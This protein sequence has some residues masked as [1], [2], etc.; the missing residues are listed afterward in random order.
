MQRNWFD[1][2]PENHRDGIRRL[3]P[4]L[5]HLSIDDWHQAVCD[6]FLANTLSPFPS[7]TGVFEVLRSFQRLERQRRAYEIVREA[8]AAGGDP[9]ELLE[10]TDEILI[11]QIVNLSDELQHEELTVR[12][13]MKSL[14]DLAAAKR[15]LSSS[16]KVEVEM[17]QHQLEK[18]AVLE[19]EVKTGE[20]DFDLATIQK[21][22][23]RLYGIFDAE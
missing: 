9:Q 8:K 22:R 20:A 17:R 11:A 6:Y 7:R 5:G 23:E 10:G 14:K 19:K 1:S 18:L 13:R 16:R 12:D 21:I 15:M 4:D 2:L 3:L